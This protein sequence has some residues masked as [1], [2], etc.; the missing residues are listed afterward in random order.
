MKTKAFESGVLKTLRFCCCHRFRDYC[1]KRKS[2]SKK[3]RCLAR[4]Y[5]YY[6]ARLDICRQNIYDQKTQVKALQDKNALQ[7]HHIEMFTYR[8]FR[9]SGNLPVLTD[10]LLLVREQRN[11][12]TRRRLQRTE[13]ITVSPICQIYIVYFLIMFIQTND[14]FLRQFSRYFALGLPL[15]HTNCTNNLFKDPFYKRY[16]CLHLKYKF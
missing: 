16:K 7:M 4:Q 12:K 5:K 13:Q 2:A 1:T 9:V 8:I 3:F 11:T 14:D 15:L 10:S 6:C